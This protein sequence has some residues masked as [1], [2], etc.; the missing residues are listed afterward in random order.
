MVYRWQ[1]PFRG[2]QVASSM[3]ITLYYA[4]LF[5]SEFS[6]FS[7]KIGQS[8]GRSDSQFAEENNN[9]NY[10]VQKCFLLMHG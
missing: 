8:F 3:V 4:T 5:F 2:A 1:T 10:R 9:Q 6:I 7:K